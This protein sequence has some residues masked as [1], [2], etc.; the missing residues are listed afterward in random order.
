MNDIIYTLKFE[1]FND[2]LLLGCPVV[3]RYGILKKLLAYSSRVPVLWYVLKFSSSVNS[4]Q[5]K[6]KKILVGFLH[7][8]FVC[9][10]QS[11]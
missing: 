6:S 2:L 10:H 3:P 8:G 11:Y 1:H 9:F 5:E 7:I 4:E